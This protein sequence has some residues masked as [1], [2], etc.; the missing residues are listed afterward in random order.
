MDIDVYDFDIED[1]NNIVI[2]QVCDTTEEAIEEDIQVTKVVG[3]KLE[4][5]FLNNFVI[6]LIV[7]NV[8][9]MT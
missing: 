6:S 9:C 4:L 2:K 1:L 7:Q 5:P 3:G 8:V